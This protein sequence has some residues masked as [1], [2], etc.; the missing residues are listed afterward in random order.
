MPVRDISRWNFLFAGMAVYPLRL[1]IA[2]LPLLVVALVSLANSSAP[3]AGVEGAAAIP[4]GTVLPIALQK[5]IGL[6]DAKPGQ[7]V[8]ARIM[9]DVPLPDGEKIR[10]KT[11][12][13]GSVVSVERDADGSGVK[14]AFKFTQLE[15]GKDTLT[16][17]TYLRAIAS[18]LAVRSAQM[19][20]AGADAGSPEGWA[21][22]TLVGGET[23]Y[24]DGGPVRH[25]K[26]KVGKGVIG[27]V[28]VRI[29]ANPA[30]G[31]EGAA[32]SEDAPQALWV[33]SSDACG[34]YGMRGVQI[35]HVGKGEP[36]GEITLHFDKQDM[37][38]EAG[39]GMLLRIAPKT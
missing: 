11:V 5:P 29:S 17:V 31:C 27:G 37:R 32:H 22:T 6:K 28:L 39:V 20:T 38:L 25:G 15:S 12:V 2:R 24:G 7:A 26:E 21:N 9:Q 13:T 35:V 19:P 3:I 33:F 23:R 4:A 16:I 14:L 8:A 10:L 1:F 36:L 34:V 30:R 18:F